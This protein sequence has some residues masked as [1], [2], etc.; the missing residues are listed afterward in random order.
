MNKLRLVGLINEWS[1]QHA[2]TC[3][4]QH[5]FS[6]RLLLFYFCSWLLCLLLLLYDLADIR[7]MYIPSTA[8]FIA[9]S[10]VD[11]SS[12]PLPRLAAHFSNVCNWRSA[13]EAQCHALFLKHLSLCFSEVL[14]DIF[15]IQLDSTAKKTKCK[16]VQRGLHGLYSL[17]ERRKEKEKRK[18]RKERKE[19]TIIT[20]A[21]VV[22]QINPSIKSINQE[23]RKDKVC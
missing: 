16:Q 10:S 23:K 17:K 4:A 15:R 21:I 6:F 1:C 18:A 12:A 22:N 9:Q 5:D 8:R 19:K 20:V 13:G 2:S 11:Q 3:R 14:N 7:P